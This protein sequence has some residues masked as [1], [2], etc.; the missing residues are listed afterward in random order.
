M[1]HAISAALAA[2]RLLT[3]VRNVRPLHPDGHR[4]E[5]NVL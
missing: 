2:A 1:K 3:S 5:R 4:E